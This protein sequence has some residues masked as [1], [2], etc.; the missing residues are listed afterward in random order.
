M[1]TFLRATI[2]SLLLIL[3]PFTALMASVLILDKEISSH[4]Y[5]LSG[6]WFLLIFP[7]GFMVFK[8]LDKVID[9]ELK[10]EFGLT[11]LFENH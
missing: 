5:S 10:E 1:K 11:E 8:V 2:F 7:H 9:K 3:P 6:V 4:L